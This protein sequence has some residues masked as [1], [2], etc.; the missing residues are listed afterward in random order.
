MPLDSATWAALALV[1]TA[2]GAAYTYVS[3]RRRGP[4][5]GVRGLAWT[6]VPIAAWLT[7]TLRLAG[8]IADAVTSWAARLVFSPVV[9]LGVVVAGVSVVLFGASE[10]MRRRGIGTRG[11]PPRDR[12][13]KKRGLEG[14]QS[15]QVA[16]PAGRQAAPSMGTDDDLADIEA[17]L[18]KHGIR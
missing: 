14:R 6:M 18:K 9:W 11:R 8:Q 5:A 17:I 7:G 1:L 12:S 10:T 13:R 15:K 3:W 2:V 16:A 4:A